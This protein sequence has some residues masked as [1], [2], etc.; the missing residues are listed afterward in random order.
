MDKK[1][2]SQLF[3]QKRAELGMSI[4]EYNFY[5]KHHPLDAPPVKVEKRRSKKK[6]AAPPP[7]IPKE[8]IE[9]I[10]E[11]EED[12]LECPHCDKTYKSISGYNHHLAS[13]HPHIKTEALQ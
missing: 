13:K 12:L 10:I 3:H 4:P 5:L 6:K 7:P 1:Q 8:V 2:R 11:P 9:E